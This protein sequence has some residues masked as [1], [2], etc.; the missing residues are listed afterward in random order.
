MQVWVDADACP[1]AIKEILFRAAIRTTTTITLVAN[2]GL[3][4]PRSPFIKKVLVAAGFD[5]ADKYIVENLQPGDLVIT[6]D[7]LLANEAID[8]GAVAL[9]PRGSMY[10]KENIKSHL[11][12]RNLNEEL[13]S[14]GMITGGPAT[15]GAKDIQTFANGLDRFL[16]SIKR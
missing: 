13:R 4:T 5:M 9:N 10:S 16:T 7:I 12:M 11:S 3:N 6:A 14:G 1:G 15:L 2:Q 8:K